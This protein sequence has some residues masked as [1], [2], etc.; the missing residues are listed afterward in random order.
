MKK[1]TIVI[2][3]PD[4][5]RGDVLRHLGNQGAVTPNLDA[6]ANNDGVSFANAFSQNPV[7][8]PSRCSFMT[9]WYTHTH[10]HRSMINM[11]K[12]HE[13]HLLKVLRNNGY[14]VWW[15][16]KNDLVAVEKYEDYFDHCDEKARPNTLQKGHRPPPPLAEDDYRH[17]A[18]Y[19]GVLPQDPAGEY[20]CYDTGIID[21]AVEKI[22]SHD[23]SKPLCLYLPIG[24]P[25]PS[26]GIEEEFYNQIDPD[27]LPPRIPTPEAGSAQ[28]PVLDSL[29]SEFGS[30][31]ITD[32][33]WLEIKRIY[34]AMC[35]RVDHFFGRVVNALKEAGLYDDALVM[36]F[37]DHGD[38]TGDY[39]LPE[40]TH[41]TL[42]DALIHV[43]FLIKPPQATT[44]KPG[45]RNSLTELVDMTATVYDLLGIDPGYAIQGK[46]LCH[47]LAGDDTDQREAVF[48]AVGARANE[49]AFR[50]NEVKSLPPN[51][52]YGRQSRAVRPHAA[53]GTYCVS[54]RTHDLKYIRR[55]YNNHHEL[56]DLRNDPGEQ[57]NLY[58]DPAMA[59]D[60]AKME[61]LL[62]DFFMRTGDILPY[63]QDSRQI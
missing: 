34:Y 25:H 39:G 48:A 11:L 16:G 30:D 51:S 35:R 49:S 2:F 37:S 14:H 55:G 44:V 28:L 58:G 19:R 56:Y 59:T 15:G 47:V 18:F 6:I 3:N 12:P 33:D 53:S 41:S 61:M 31:K 1:P 38:F 9:G 29:R 54:C 5:Y 26:Y 7:C 43:P 40:K 27:S 24:S 45:I 63:K 32:A 36:F 52:F 4:S 50:N 62:L 20:H 21:A 23:N 57:N 42:Q 8:T 60:Q 46:S 13:P 22:A 10:G 17:G